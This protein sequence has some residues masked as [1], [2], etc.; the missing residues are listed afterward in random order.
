MATFSKF[1]DVMPA[2]Y[3]GVIFVALSS[4]LM[5][6]WMAFNVVKARKKYNVEYP[7]LYSNDCKEFNC[8]QRAHQNSLEVYPQFLLLLFVGGLQ[9][10]KVA[11]GAGLM[12]LI[13][14]FLYARGYSSGDPEKR[15]PGAILDHIAQLV[16]LGQGICVVT[17]RLGLFGSN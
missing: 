14:R 9:N 16:L 15:R 4:T 12:Y 3:E 17:R 10:P 11:S 1:F 7:A 2:C 5:N 8:I 13:G 6:T